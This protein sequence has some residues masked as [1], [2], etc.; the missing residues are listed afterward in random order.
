MLFNKKSY[1]V[2]DFSNLVYISFFA[3]YRG[4]PTAIPLH[5][6]AH[7]AYFH[8]CIGSYRRWNGLAD[9]VYALD[10][11]PDEKY[12]LHPGYKAGRQK[13]SHKDGSRFNALQPILDSM[14]QATTIKA[15]GYEADD[16]MAS[17]VAQNFEDEIIIVTTDKD[18]WCVA[19]HP[20]A[21]VYDPLK[22]EFIDKHHVRAS[23]C[24]KDKH[25]V[26]QEHLTEFAQ[27]KLFKTLWGDSSDAIPN[28]VLRTKNE[29]LPLL[30]TTDGSLEDFYDKVAAAK[31]TPKCRLKISEA[32][33]KIILNNKLV[34]LN[35]GCVL[36]Q[37]TINLPEVEEG[38]LWGAHGEYDLDKIF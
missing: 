15:D 20:N 18:L 34:R 31:L 32:K 17:F 22:R 16:A 24:R 13:L 21:R 3:A 23:F 29:L 25:K 30:T 4:E 5:Y 8:N 9:F 6:D 2:V 14:G 28:V 35:Y 19:D 11:R 7:V 12:R 10:T 26:V 33:E 27:I 37:E 36:Q 1:V 38:P